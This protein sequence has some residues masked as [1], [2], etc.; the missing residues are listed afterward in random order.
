MHKFPFRHDI[1]DN[2]ENTDKYRRNIFRANRIIRHGSITI[3]H[4]LVLRRL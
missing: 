4:P 3:H 2:L 1:S